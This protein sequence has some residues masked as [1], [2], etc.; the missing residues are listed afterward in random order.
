MCV[1]NFDDGTVEFLNMG[2]FFKN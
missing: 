2:K 1:N